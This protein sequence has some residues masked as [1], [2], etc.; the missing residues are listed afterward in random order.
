MAGL[1]IIEH[2]SADDDS[3]GVLRKLERTVMQIA[4]EDPLVRHFY[5]GIASGTDYRHALKRRFDAKKKKW[6]I[7]MMVAIFETPYQPHCRFAE[8]CLE[9]YF[10]KIHHD[11]VSM[12]TPLNDADIKNGTGGG[13]GRNS[14]QPFHYIYVAV[15]HLGI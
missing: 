11:M 5:I 3:V 8:G 13:G 12:D 2:I 7:N 15:K 1:T 4:R 9:Q 10:Q 6:G 14:E